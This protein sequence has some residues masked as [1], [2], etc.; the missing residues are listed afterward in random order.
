[1]AYVSDVD[2]NGDDGY[3][4]YVKNCLVGDCRELKSERGV[5]DVDDD[6]DDGYG[7]YVKKRHK[8]GK[9]VTFT[10]NI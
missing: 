2:D 4:E 5:S 10:P 9:F 3:G 8:T 1:M 6:G 7:E